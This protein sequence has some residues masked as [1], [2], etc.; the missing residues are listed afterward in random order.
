MRLLVVK[1]VQTFAHNSYVSVA[2][3]QLPLSG[4]AGG[5]MHFDI[6]IMSGINRGAE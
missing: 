3:S 1:F 5:G 2:V 4:E 6:S